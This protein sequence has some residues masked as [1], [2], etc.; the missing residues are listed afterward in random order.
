MAN[1]NQRFSWPGWETVELIGRGSFGAVYKIQREVFDDIEKAALKVISIPQNAGDIDDMYS[2]GYDEESITSAFQSHLKSIVA[3]Y[4]LMRKMNGCTNIVNCDDVRYVQHDDG[5]GWDIYIKMEL[6]TPLTKALPAKVSEETVIK[7]AKDICTALELCKKHEIVHRDIKPQNIFVSDNGDYKLG[8]F[9]IAKTVEKTMGGTKIGTYK[10]MAPEVYNNQPYGSAADIYSLGLVLYW[11]LNDRRMPFL[12]LPPEKIKAGMDEEARHRRLSGEKLPA[13]THGSKR[14]KEIVLKACAFDPKERY[15]T[16]TEML[17]DLKKLED[18]NLV[19]AP[20]TKAEPKPSVQ[21]E[22]IDTSSLPEVVPFGTFDNGLDTASWDKPKDIKPV[23][24]PASSDKASLNVQGDTK[25]PTVAPAQT[26]VT[27]TDTGAEKN[28]ATNGAMN[29]HQNQ[30]ATILTPHV[31]EETTQREKGKRHIARGIIVFLILVIGAC[32]INT[33]ESVASGICGHEL[34]WKLSNDGTLTISGTGQMTSFTTAN[35][36]PWYKHKNQ[37]TTVIVRNGVTSISNNAF[38]NYDNLTA[39]KLSGSVQEIGYGAFGECSS[40]TE[41]TYDGTHS[42]WTRIEIESRNEALI[43]AY[44]KSTGIDVNDNT[45]TA[46]TEENQ[47]SEWLLELPA[48]VS[49]ENCLIEERLIYRSRTL[50]TTSSTK[51]SQMDGWE[52]YNTVDKAGEYGEW[53]N[54]SESKVTSTDSR[55]VQ[56]ELRYRYR[57]KQFST[58]STSTMSGWTLYDT[59]YSWGDYGAWSGWSTTVYSSSSSRQIESKTQYR[60]R[61]I[62]ITQAYSDWGNWSSWSDTSES[63]SNLKKE[64]TR[65]VWAY[66]YFLCPSCNAHVYGWGITCPTWAGGCGKAYV[67]E[68]SWHAVWST[69]SW[70]EANLKDYY[71]TGKYYTYI[72]GELVYKWTSGGN[73][74][75]YRYATRTLYDVVN[76]GSWSGYS[77]TV[78]TASSSRDVSSRVVYRYRDRSQIA[79]YHFWKWGTY[80]NWSTEKISASG[81]RDVDTKTFYRYRDKISST[82]YYFRRWGEW[83]EYTTTPI[84]DTDTI[85]VETVKQYRYKLK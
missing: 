24:Q 26:T 22:P 47:Y 72:N 9:G 71:G 64:E 81:A 80:S 36:A 42:A 2:D 51:N 69:V 50:E 17:A 10:Y 59:S 75:Q 62:W 35:Q 6:L 11:A 79:T 46:D 65:T 66:F 73:K 15:H 25:Q 41:A 52:L 70:N 13:P 37:I 56:S 53:S 21:S 33:C 48:G 78:Y 14:L 57:D 23:A 29:L 34:T 63:T 83:T 19:V 58:S 32:I 60:Y 39:V 1:E 12:P 54:W 40:L 77:D 74:N 68:S 28:S 8:D 45:G 16:A 20:P 3:E 43:N 76:Y 38:F 44:Y 18:G 85:Q 7:I 61:D 82:T 4:S 49:T 27:K 67:P 55:Q 5:V 30:Q 31:A 84:Y